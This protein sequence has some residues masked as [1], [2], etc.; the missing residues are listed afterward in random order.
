[1][2]TKIESVLDALDLKYDWKKQ[3][4]GTWYGLVEF[5]TD[6]ADQDVP[7]EFEFDGTAEDFVKKFR[8]AADN[9]DVDEKVESY[10]GVRGRNG[11]PDTVTELLKDCQ[12]AKDTL[13][14]I[15]RALENALDGNDEEDAGTDGVESLLEAIDAGLS[16]GY[17]VLEGDHETLYVKDRETGKHYSIRVEEC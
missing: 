5:W 12:E 2:M 1:M 14:R 17:V 13:T 9:Y 8:S 11:V 10:V 15:A 16:N 3:D 6:T 7:V 4:D